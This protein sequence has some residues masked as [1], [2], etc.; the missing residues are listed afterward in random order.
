MALSNILSAIDE[1]TSNE[2]ATIK[3]EEASKQA[4]LKAEYDKKLHAKKEEI[5]KKI[6][7]ATDRKVSQ[8]GFQVQSQ[9]SGKV[10]AKKR[11][12]IDSVFD[13]VL[14]KLSSLSDDD[15]K[16]LLVKLIKNLPEVESGEIVPVKGSESTV[17]TAVQEAGVKYDVSSETTEG[18]G[19]FI[20]KSEG[21]VIDNSWDTLA[22]GQKD[23]FESEIANTIFYG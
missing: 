5:L 13:K 10:L 22:M 15:A 14:E 2:I 21:L 16:K 18:K 4:A 11:E 12:I 8:A 9:I 20:F 3:K 6:K 17:K 19:G 7:A 1:K 23:T